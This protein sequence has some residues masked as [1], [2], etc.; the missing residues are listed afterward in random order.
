[1]VCR[2]GVLVGVVVVDAGEAKERVLRR[3]WRRVRRVEAVRKVKPAA[4]RVSCLVVRAWSRWRSGLVGEVFSGAGGGL[5]VGG[6]VGSVGCGGVG[7]EG[8]GEPVKGRRSQDIGLLVGVVIARE[9]EG[10]VEEAED[11]VVYRSLAELGSF[12]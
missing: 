12:D 7:E 2:V 11:G 5:G 9:A 8:E 1:M 6:G 10:E 4:R 3:M